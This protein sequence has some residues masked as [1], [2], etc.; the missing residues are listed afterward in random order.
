MR[1]VNIC[2]DGGFVKLQTKLL[3]GGSV[4][5][6]ACSEL[7]A[8]RGFDPDKFESFVVDF[9]TN[10]AA[11]VPAPLTAAEPE[12][13]PLSGDTDAADGEP[14]QKQEKADDA[15]KD[16]EMED[17]FYFAKQQYPIIQI[18]K[19]GEYGK[20]FPY[21][22]TICK[23]ATWPEGKV[24]EMSQAKAYSV[25]H[26]IKQHLDSSK[27]K[28]NLQRI[29]S[30]K[31]GKE[32]E[33]LLVD[34]QALSVSHPTAK[35]LYECRSEF[36]V[37][38]TFTNFQA[39]AKHTYW[40]E[41]TG[42]EDTWYIRSQ[43][44]SKKVEN[45]AGR[46]RQVCDE[47]LSLGQAHGVARSVVRFSLKYFSAKLLAARIFHGKEASIQLE[48]D[49][50]QSVIFRK[51]PDKVRQILSLSSPRLQQFVR[52]AVCSEPNKSANM[53]S[54]FTTVVEPSLQ[55]NLNNIPDRL[56]DVMG[57][58][59][60]CIRSG[61]SSELDLAHLKIATAVLSGSLDNHP[62]VLGLTLQC[63]R[64]LEKQQRGIEDMRGRRTLETEREKCLIADCGS[65]L[66]ILCG[67][68][69]LAREFGLSLK[70]A[71]GRV[72]IDELNKHSLPHPALALWRTDTLKQNFLLADQ[73][74]QRHP[75][76]PRCHLAKHIKTKK[77]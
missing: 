18:L 48:E 44:C 49:F 65:Q 7:L 2:E 68:K 74:F 71:S 58:F 72:F 75:D 61:D 25:E 32:D 4:K 12:S 1:G 53:H 8:S 39:H 17:P 20:T 38:A 70:V 6:P 52:A 34:C 64:L 43:K 45:L 63:H 30:E 69:P 47:C 16:A 46:E 51:D 56:T 66:A 19:P 37:W 77:Y 55:V 21:R 29:E 24:G 23:S 67:N 15:D 13:K 54:F 36:G 14:K 60:A 28:R 62:M 73:R 22:C 11:A 50:K 76:Q 33:V 9:L 40:R 41:A 10:P 42:S 5:C 31:A 59:T 26:F 27:H 3:Q 57:Q 35:A